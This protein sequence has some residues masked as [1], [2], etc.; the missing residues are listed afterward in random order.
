MVSCRHFLLLDFS[1][2]QSSQG[3]CCA[4]VIAATCAF[5]RAVCVR[6]LEDAFV[7]PEIEVV[8]LTWKHVDIVVNLPIS[9]AS[10]VELSAVE[11]RE[12]LPWNE[13]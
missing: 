3:C 2:R 4:V 11:L 7:Y 8:N 10:E 12:S 1:V 9:T 6:V 13:G 5:P